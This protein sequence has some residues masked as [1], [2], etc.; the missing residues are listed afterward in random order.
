KK[1]P[2]NFRG[3]TSYVLRQYKKAAGDLEMRGLRRWRGV[4]RVLLEEAKVGLRG[5]CGMPGN[6]IRAQSKLQG[7]SCGLL[8]ARECRLK[9]YLLNRHSWP[10]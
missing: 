6:I 3:V 4:R 8:P 2:S 7:M 1:S 9:S 5:T 10:E